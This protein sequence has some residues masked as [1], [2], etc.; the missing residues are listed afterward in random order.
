MYNKCDKA[1]AV[2]FDPDIILTSAKT[3]Q[4]LGDLLAALDAALSD[5]VRAVKLILPYDKLGLAE[6]MRVRGSVAVEDY[7]EDGVYF[8]GFVKSSDL[9]LYLPYLLEN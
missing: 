7:R 4:G 6:A 1:G 3:G 9:H 2:P 5:R 8:E